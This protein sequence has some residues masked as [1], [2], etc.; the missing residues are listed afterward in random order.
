MATAHVFCYDHLGSRRPRVYFEGTLRST[1]AEM[2][3]GKELVTLPLTVPWLK[4][5]A[6]KQGAFQRS[7]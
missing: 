4:M 6:H 3:R 5:A 1:G 2:L 7:F